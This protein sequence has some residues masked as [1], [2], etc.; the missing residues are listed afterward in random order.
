MYNRNALGSRQ[1]IQRGGRYDMVCVF[2]A[3]WQ[4]ITEVWVGGRECNA[5]VHDDLMGDTIITPLFRVCRIAL[6]SSLF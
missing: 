5:W 2:G 6:Q 4:L 1:L 3:R